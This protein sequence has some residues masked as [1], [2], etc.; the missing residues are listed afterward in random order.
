MRSRGRIHRN[1]HLCYNLIWRNNL[2]GRN[3]N[4]RAGQELDCYYSPSREPAAV[5]HQRERASLHGLL[6]SKT[7]D[8]DLSSTWQRP[9]QKKQTNAESDSFRHYALITLRRFLLVIGLDGIALGSRKLNSGDQIPGL[10]ES[11]L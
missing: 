3:R 2:P 7:G 4:A 10:E 8:D 11:S 9:Q 6:R 5:D 1:L